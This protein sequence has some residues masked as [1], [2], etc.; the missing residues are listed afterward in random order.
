MNEPAREGFINDC[1]LRRRS[2]IQYGEIAAAEQGNPKRSKEARC[3][4]DCVNQACVFIYDDDTLGCRM[5]EQPW[6]RHAGGDYSRRGFEPLQHLAANAAEPARGIR[7]TPH[8]G[9]DLH[10]AIR[11]KPKTDGS[12][13]L[14]AADK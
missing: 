1:H 2:P 6:L 3:N 10:D 9:P 11:F 13:L 4:S 8:Y 12:Q 14:K 5:A 7:G